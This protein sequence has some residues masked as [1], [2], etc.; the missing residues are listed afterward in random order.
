MDTRKRIRVKIFA[1]GNKQGNALI[2]KAPKGKQFTEQGIAAH[3]DNI[4]N[5]LE[6]AYPKDDFRMIELRDGQVNFV[7]QGERCG[8]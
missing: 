7:H 4:A 3:L 6:K 1:P 2:I 5:Q 8:S